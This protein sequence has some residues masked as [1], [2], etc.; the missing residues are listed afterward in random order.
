MSKKLN[1]L[2]NLRSALLDMEQDLGIVEMGDLEKQ[3]FLAIADLDQKNG[4]AA[5]KDLITHPFVQNFSRPSMF[6]SLKALEKSNKI[7]K[8]GLTRGYYSVVVDG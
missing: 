5:T 7:K 8:V 1:A 6:R 2:I 3:V 4:C